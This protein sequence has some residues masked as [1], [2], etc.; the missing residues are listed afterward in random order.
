MSRFKSKYPLWLL[1]L[2]TV[3]PILNG[4]REMQ[5]V[6]SDD[7]GAILG[8]TAMVCLAGL[9]GFAIRNQLRR[10]V[11]EIGDGFISHGSI[12]RAIRSRARVSDI[13]TMLS[14]G[15]AGIVLQ[16]RSGGRCKVSLSEVAPQQR[17]AARDAINDIIDSDS[18]ST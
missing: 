12:F 15:D 18:V 1:V 3:V 14:A 6:S 17:D 8:L 2:A 9:F 5:R 16:M 10:P 13:A 7:G 4:Y 11:V